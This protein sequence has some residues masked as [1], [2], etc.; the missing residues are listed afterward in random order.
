MRNINRSLVNFG[1]RVSMP[2]DRD[3]IADYSLIGDS[4]NIVDTQL[5]LGVNGTFFKLFAE[6]SVAP[7]KPANMTRFD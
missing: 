2:F 6:H 3:I 7:M 1:Q 5:N 4:I